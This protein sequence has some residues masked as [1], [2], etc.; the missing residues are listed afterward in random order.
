MKK[1]TT[2]AWS[3]RQQRNAVQA[4]R[5]TYLLI[6]KPQPQPYLQGNV[7][8]L[9][10]I[11]VGF[12]LFSA[13]F[14]LVHK[15]S[16]FVL[17]NLKFSVFACVCVVSVCN[18]FGCIFCVVCSMLCYSACSMLSHWWRCFPHLIVICLFA[19]IFSRCY[20]MCSWGHIGL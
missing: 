12:A 8:V 15:I 16:S 19:R 18:S 10:A 1:I 4:N 14:V 3:Y 7:L 9:S 5:D 20:L 13:V 17:C 11:S 2:K 6:W